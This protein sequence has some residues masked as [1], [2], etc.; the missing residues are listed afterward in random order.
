M[1]RPPLTSAI[2]GADCG[3]AGREIDADR[4]VVGT[5]LKP[6]SDKAPKPLGLTRFSK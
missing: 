5:S 2:V 4:T 1:R 6:K 3:R